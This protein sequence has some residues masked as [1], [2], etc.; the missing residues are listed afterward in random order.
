MKMYLVDARHNA[1][2][3]VFIANQIREK[4]YEQGNRFSS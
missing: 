4:I 3:I 2:D 1:R